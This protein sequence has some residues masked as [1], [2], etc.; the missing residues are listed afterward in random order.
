M[1]ELRILPD[2]LAT[3]QTTLLAS[4]PLES[5]AIAF[6]GW[7]AT[8]NGLALTLRDFILAS[9]A[10]YL[11][12]GPS[13]AVVRPEFLAPAI[14]RARSSG[15]A[16]LLCHTHPFSS[17]PSFSGIDDGGEDVLI[18]RVQDRAPRAPHG[19]MVLGTAGASVRVW[20]PGSDRAAPATLRIFGE[21]PASTVAPPFERQER[22]LG[23]GSSRALG[24]RTLGVIGVGGLGWDVATLAWQH[25]FGR[26]VL[27]DPDTIE[28][29]NRPRLRGSVPS[30][31]GASKAGT[32]AG[33]LAKSRPDADA[34][35]V[36][37]PIESAAARSAIADIDI[38]VCATD[39]LRSRL[40][41]DRLFRS[42]L[43]PVI[44]VGINLEVDQ[45]HLRRVG[46]RMS[47]LWP[48]GPCLL[49]MGVFGPDDVAREA[50]PLGYRND[51]DGRAEA[52]IASFNAVL[53]GL[54]VS[55]V[56][57]SLL[58]TRQ[59]PTAGRYLVYDG[60]KGLV[61]EVDPGQP[62]QCGTCGRLA[63]SFVGSGAS[64]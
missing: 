40:E 47:T 38:A 9:D 42:L 6:A 21:W 32:L 11:R 12:R 51:G 25:G 16:L 58:G 15:E 7:R 57:M 39:T 14:K 53:A 50:D 23:P 33:F 28:A 44:D 52:A 22:A 46:G 56:L 61:R 60:L 43:V 29:H 45:G 55:E 35:A 24:S 10:D 20:E 18:P 3:L 2:Q 37:A 49:C 1:I 34:V 54:A 63:G 36:V 8:G 19:G 4:S 13:G 64:R 5:V 30:D 48:T 26:L 31:D 62:G 41:V 59:L 27:I 17:H